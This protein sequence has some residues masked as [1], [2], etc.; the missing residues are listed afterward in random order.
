MGLKIYWTEFSE[1]ELENIFKYHRKKAGYRIARKLIDGI[2]NETLKLRK[3]PEIGQAE[4]L[5]KGRKQNFRYLVYKSYKV[6]IG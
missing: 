3:Q 2:Y 5:L 6:F 1:K 4:E